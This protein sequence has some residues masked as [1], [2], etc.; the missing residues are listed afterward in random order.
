MF[1]KIALV[2]ICVAVVFVSLVSAASADVVE[3]TLQGYCSTHAFAQAELVEWN[4]TDSNDAYGET[5]ATANALAMHGYFDEN[6]NWIYSDKWTNTSVDIT[7]TNNSISSLGS[8]TG[9]GTGPGTSR[10]SVDNEFNGTITI[11]TSEAYPLGTE[12]LILNISIGGSWG[13]FQVNSVWISSSTEIEVSAGDNLTIN[14]IHQ[15]LLGE[16]DTM[17]SEAV[18]DFSVTPE[19]TTMLLLGLGGLALIRRKRK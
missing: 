7:A 16:W 17:N 1:S 12:G 6:D 13:V 8:I 10:G 3:V 5:S 2:I 14:C 15:E 18:A 9:G 4:I 11:G 19:P